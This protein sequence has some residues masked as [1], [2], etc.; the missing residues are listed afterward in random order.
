MVRFPRELD[1][2]ACI[3][4]QV[5]AV[6]VPRFR[7]AWV[8]VQIAMAALDFAVLRAAL[9]YPSPSCLL[10]TLGAMPTA[11]VLAIGLLIG[12]CRLCSRP[13]ILGFEWFGALASA[14][15]VVLASY[16]RDETVAPYLG[17]FIDPLVKLIGQNRRFFVPIAY[18]GIAVML[19]LPQLAF[20]LLGGVLWRRFTSRL[21]HT[22]RFDQGL[23]PEF[24]FI[25]PHTLTPDRPCFELAKTI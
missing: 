9:D 25:A 11:T 22:Y 21:F 5:V 12:Y 20:A 24:C 10:S 19:A 4:A 3:Y 23:L 17:L 16:L 13:F 15:Y 7:I 14:L 8:M 18:P 6:K 1:G 2:S